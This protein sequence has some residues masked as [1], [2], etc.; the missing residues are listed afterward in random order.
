M[1]PIFFLDQ[2]KVGHLFAKL[3][4]IGDYRAF[5]VKPLVWHD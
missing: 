5:V 2:R 4:K 3:A 1:V